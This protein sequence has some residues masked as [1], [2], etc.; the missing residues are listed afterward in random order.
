MGSEASA[1]DVSVSAPLAREDRGAML[2]ELPEGHNQ[3]VDV[4]YAGLVSL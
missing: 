1:I 4:P 2:S 3:E